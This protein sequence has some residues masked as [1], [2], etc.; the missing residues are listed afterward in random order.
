M[1]RAA[2]RSGVLALALMVSFASQAAVGPQ[3]MSEASASATSAN[4]NS[5]NWNVGGY[6]DFTKNS[7]AYYD[8]VEFSASLTAKY[9]LINRLALGIGGGVDAGP[10]ESAAASVGPAASYF[11][12]SD[13]KLAAHADLGFRYGLTDTTV[14]WFITSQIGVNY[15]FTPSVAMGPS[16]YLNHYS[17]RYADFQRYGAQVNIG[18]YL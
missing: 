7:G 3:M 4:I 8:D 12:W 9:F 14:P 16:V 11:F 13:G 15:F 10:G 1:I 2:L 6:F 5:G 17:S 18:V